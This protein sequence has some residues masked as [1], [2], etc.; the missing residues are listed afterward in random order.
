MSRNRRRIAALAVTVAAGLAALVAATA[1][2]AS[3]VNAEC[4]TYD[5]VTHE[6][7][8]WPEGQMLDTDQGSIECHNGHWDGPNVDSPMPGGG[9]DVAA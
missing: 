3:T 1:A 5:R 4:P 9:G 8:W 2:P 7:E 6:E